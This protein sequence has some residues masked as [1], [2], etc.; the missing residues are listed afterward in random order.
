MVR[1]FISNKISEFVEIRT[2]LS[3]IP[4]EELKWHWDEEDREIEAAENTD[5]KFQFDNQLPVEI[6]KK[7]FIPKGAIHRVI[8]GAGDLKLKITKWPI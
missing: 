1:P 4:D 6:N 3:S 7:I 8:K 5:W 2:F